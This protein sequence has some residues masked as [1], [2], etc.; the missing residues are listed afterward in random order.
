MGRK[1]GNLGHGTEA[2]PLAESHIAGIR[3]YATGEDFHERGFSGAIR[4]DQ[5]DA[6]ALRNSKG[7]ILKQRRD[8]VA[9]RKRLSAEN[10]WQIQEPRKMILSE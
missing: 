8:P 4:A 7:D 6:F 2:S 9:F 3:F 1:L 10:R 5:A